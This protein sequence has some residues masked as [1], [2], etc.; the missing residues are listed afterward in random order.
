MQNFKDLKVWDKAHQ[1]T[2]SIY[3]ISASFPKEEVY[4]LTN[5]LRRAS[6]SIPANIAE[7]CGKNSQA[8]LA[9]FLNISLGSANETEYFLILSK[10]LDYL[11]EEQ[12]TILSNSINEVKAMLISLIL[13]V[14][15][16]H[17]N[18]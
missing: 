9:N 6:A 11:A 4:S 2:L 13:K 12:F 8:D 7:G 18:L 16:K 5:Q 1:L 15:T 17:R 14:R 10:D 3:K